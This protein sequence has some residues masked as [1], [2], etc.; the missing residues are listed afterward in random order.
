M[1]ME[2]VNFLLVLLCGTDSWGGGG[3]AGCCK[4]GDV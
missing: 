3:S 4:W 2:L 1:H